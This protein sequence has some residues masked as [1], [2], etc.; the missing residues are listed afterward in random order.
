VASAGKALTQQSFLK[1]VSGTL[2]AVTDP[3]RSASKFIEN[4]AGSLV[5]NFIKSPTR[6]LDSLQRQS[7]SPLDAVKSGIPGL[8]Q[9]LTPK[10]DPYG[11]DMKRPSSAINSVINPG[12]PSDIKPAD[13]TTQELRRLQDAGVGIMTPTVGKTSASSDT[14]AGIK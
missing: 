3:A 12:R 11:Q 6:G 5:P 7:N 13:A 2:D 4:T 8:R 1:G 9:T 14:S 10:V